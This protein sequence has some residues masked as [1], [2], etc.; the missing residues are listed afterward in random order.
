MH[1]ED[2]AELLSNCDEVTFSFCQIRIVCLVPMKTTVYCIEDF[3]TGIAIM[4][5][6]R[7]MVRP[8][9]TT[10][11]MALIQY[12]CLL[13][14]NK[15]K[16]VKGFKEFSTYMAIMVGNRKRARIG[17]SIIPRTQLRYNLQVFLQVPVAMTRALRHTFITK[18]N[19]LLSI[20]DNIFCPFS[21]GACIASRRCG[22]GGLSW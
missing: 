13:G 14:S 19:D 8:N 15:T 16:G 9:D 3:S 4:M 18:Q 21:W 11:N 7:K 10:K 2:K 20:P 12:V 5:K 17:I 1:E 6:N 22:G